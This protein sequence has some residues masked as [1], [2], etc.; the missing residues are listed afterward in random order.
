MTT[1][2][3]FALASSH[4]LKGI[5]LHGI[6]PDLKFL[7]KQKG[8]LDYLIA[9]NFIFI[10]QRMC[11]NFLSTMTFRHDQCWF[12]QGSRAEQMTYRLCAE[13]TLWCQQHQ[14]LVGANMRPPG[15]ISKTTLAGRMSPTTLNSGNSNQLYQY[16]RVSCGL[17]TCQ[18]TDHTGLSIVFARVDVNMVHNILSNGSLEHSRKSDISAR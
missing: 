2:S 8:L 3:H 17:I 5:D 15:C 1:V 13:F 16:P 10:H 7:K 18:F 14:V 12:G 9:F 11:R 4:S 6:I